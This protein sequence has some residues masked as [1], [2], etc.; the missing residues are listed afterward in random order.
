MKNRNLLTVY[1]ASFFLFL[2][3]CDSVRSTFGLDHYEPDAFAI[4]QNPSLTLPPDYNLAPPI[5]GAKNPG[6][7]SAE[8]KAQ[9]AV[10]SGKNVS[11]AKGSSQS[12]SALL[13]SASQG[14]DVS[15]DIR[16]TVDAEA[17]E[18]NPLMNKLTSLKNQAVKNLSGTSDSSSQ[19]DIEKKEG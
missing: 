13:H 3:G 18:D 2:S 8:S 6:E 1:C 16:K 12:E 4:A 17:E 9:K 10:F 5:P 19:A 14:K 7:E 15:S 11:P